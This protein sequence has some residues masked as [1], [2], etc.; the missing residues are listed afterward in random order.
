M[1]ASL[2]ILA[3]CLL[4]IPFEFITKGEVTKERLEIAIVAFLVVGFK[5]AK[6]PSQK[7]KLAL[8]YFLLI[9]C[10]I[11]ILLFLF[12]LWIAIE[13]DFIIGLP[14]MSICLFTYYCIFKAMRSKFLKG[15]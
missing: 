4:V 8:E 14:L 7:R 12:S 6:S 2:W 3:V 9:A 11:V 10:F 1:I 15:I 13:K 5:V